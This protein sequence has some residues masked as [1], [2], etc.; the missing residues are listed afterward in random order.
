MAER[1]A[2]RAKNGLC[3]DA[4]SEW[5]ALEYNS[6]FNNRFATEAVPGA[7]PVGQNSP[8]VAAHGL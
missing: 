6:G 3:A 2:K 4:A 1:P 7:L 8:Q 5:N